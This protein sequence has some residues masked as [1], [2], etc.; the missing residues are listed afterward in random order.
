MQSEPEELFSTL[1]LHNQ[2]NEIS[3]QPAW[4]RPHSALSHWVCTSA[5]WSLALLWYCLQRCQL[6]PFVAAFVKCLQRTG[7]DP[8]AARSPKSQLS[9]SRRC[10]TPTHALSAPRLIRTPGQ[11]NRAPPELLCQT[12]QLQNLNS[13]AVEFKQISECS[14]HKP[15]IMT[16]VSEASFSC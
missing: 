1:S 7:H 3:W 12:P 11:M 13:S 10:F 9:H 14:A 16:A 6:V 4:F 8:V 5:T 2:F 15:L